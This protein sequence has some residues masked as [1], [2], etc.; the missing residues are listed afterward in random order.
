MRKIHPLLAITFLLLLAFNAV[1]QSNSKVDGT[2]VEQVPCSPYQPATYEQYVEAAKRRQLEDV[3]AAKEEGFQTDASKNSPPVLMQRD[4]FAKRKA[5]PGFECHR[6]KY[7]SDGLIVAG[8]IWK[9]KDTE[10]KKLPL[11]IFNRGG[12]REFGKLTP[13]MRSGFYEYLA[14]GFVVIGSQYR[15]NDGGE[16]KEEMGGADIRDVQHLIPLAQ[17]LG[18]VDMRNIF[19]FGW[20]RGGMM[21]LLALKNNLPVN[22]AAIGGAWTDL[23]LEGKRRPLLVKEDWKELIPN[24]SEQSEEAL[25][26]RSAVYWPEKINVPLLILHGGADWRSDTGGNALALA[27]KLQGL[28]KTYELIIYAND[29]HGLSFNSAD[30]DRRIIAWFKRHMK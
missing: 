25:H 4:E 17:S 13:W 22:A 20:S 24:F 3:E 11:I 10:G 29:N 15:G 21:S 6:I 8:F 19:L 7:T 2:I 16:G 28:G 26:E 18:Y 27:Q 5:Y 23:V 30:A 1:A 14:N 9:P 12:N